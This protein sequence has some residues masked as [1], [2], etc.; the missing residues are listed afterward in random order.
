MTPSRRPASSHILDDDARE[1]AMTSTTNTRSRVPHRGATAFWTLGVPAAVVLGTLAWALSVRARLPEPVAVHWGPDGAD[2][3]GS[4][5]ELVALPL[6]VVAPP[7][8]I[9]M[10]ALASFLGQAALTRRIAAA[11]SVWTATFVSGV[12][13]ATVAAQLDAPAWSAAGDLTTGVVVSLVVATALAALAARLS[14]G[15]VP[16]PTTA[17]PSA[18]AARL[19]LG[20]HEHATWVRSTHQAGLGWILGAVAL[21]TLVL[22][23]ATRDVLLAAVLAV[24]LTL[25]LLAMTAWTVTVDE[26]GLTVASRLGRPRLHVPLSEVESAST[27]DVRPL[28]EFGGWGM[29]TSV[30]TGATAVVLRAGTAIDVQRTGGRRFVATVDDAETGAAL[31]NTLAARSR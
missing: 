27:R 21:V 24:V 6:A 28:G 20:D 22:G 12:T 19:A 30:V 31:L 17:P 8:A 18:D 4:F 13:L 16:Q 9:G 14:P 7:I 29:R 26:R 23:L 10:W 15:D 25:P 1:R 2:A 3:A 11:T 5:A